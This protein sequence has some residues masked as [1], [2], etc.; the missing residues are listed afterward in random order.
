LACSYIWF[1]TF[2]GGGTLDGSG[3]FFSNPVSGSEQFFIFAASG[4]LALA[5]FRLLKQFK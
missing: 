4:F 3:N 2:G 1:F 5:S